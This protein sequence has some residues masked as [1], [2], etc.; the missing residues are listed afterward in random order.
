MRIPGKEDIKRE[1]S[2]HKLGLVLEI[3]QNSG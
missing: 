3:I 1:T 2:W